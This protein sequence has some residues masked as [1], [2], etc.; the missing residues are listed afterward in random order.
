MEQKS[1]SFQLQSTRGLARAGLINTPH[2]QIETPIFMPVGTSASVKS[3]DSQDLLELSAEVILANTYHLNLRP[4][5]EVL[6]KFGGVHN[7]MGWNKPMLTDSGGF[8][9][10]S[11]GS[12]QQ[13]QPDSK[14]LVKISD[15]GV[16][17]RSHLDGSI[18][19]FTPEK[20][21]E[22]QRI[23]GADIIMAFDECSP[24]T[25]DRQYLE[26]SLSRTHAW[27]ERC[28]TYHQSK[29]YLSQ[30]GNYQALFG[31]IQGGRDKNL[32]QKSAGF[33]A[34]LPF[35]GLAVGGE[36][37]GY[38]MGITADIMSWIEQTL[39]QDKPR[40]AMGLGRDPQ[41]II[42]AVLLGFDMFDCV[43]PTRLARNGAL[44]VG[45]V[46]RTSSRVK[47][48]SD[49]PK[50]RLSI[51]NAQ[52]ASDSRPIDPQCQCHTC[53][54]GYS[55]AYL[56][57]LYKSKELSYYRLASIHNLYFMIKLAKTIRYWVM[58]KA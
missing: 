55:R 43:G 3:L 19:Y 28:I 56:H 51:D 42:D 16:E 8:Q 48:I 15:D 17:F 47:F 23:I 36:S 50:G 35:D 1:F 30:Y 4:G 44:F 11:L 18:H 32:R 37:I 29:Q 5:L 38:Q 33:L 9:V 6:S 53:I 22:I 34:A 52:Y 58:D 46:E 24:D 27:A 20:S 41:D 12:Q 7:L 25:L 26:R 39:P 49:F 45:Q 21:I 40:Y 10:F 31:I 57:H 2:G 54:N 14:S 13:S